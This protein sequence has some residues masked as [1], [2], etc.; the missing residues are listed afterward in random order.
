MN[1]IVG[2]TEPMFLNFFI[3]GLQPEIQRELLINPPKNLTEAMVK[4]QLFEE[5]NADLRVRAHQEGYHTGTTT[6]VPTRVSA[7]GTS[8][9]TIPIQTPTR[10]K[11]TS[12]VKPHFK[13]L[14]PAEVQEKREKGLCFTC[15][16]KYNVNHRCK[17]RIMILMGDEL[18]ASSEAIPA[19][20]QP[21]HILDS[22]EDPEVSLHTLTNASSHHI[23]RLTTQIHQ[24]T[25]EVLID[26]GSHNNFIQEDL[27]EKWGSPMKMQ[28]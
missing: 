24:K 19:K 9:G 16:E 21:E 25:V 18:D 13:I 1:R 4:A 11:P 28:S 26:T 14:S 3:W 2:I 22:E 10:Y 12:T 23:F 17:N 5:H 20:S 27:V 6:T 15:D 8:T 7:P